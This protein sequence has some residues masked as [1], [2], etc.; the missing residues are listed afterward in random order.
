MS[1]TAPA[2]SYS[3]HAGLYIEFL[4]TD[5]YLPLKER[6]CALLAHTY[7]RRVDTGTLMRVFGAN[8]KQVQNALDALAKV[9]RISRTNGN[10][11]LEV[12]G[13]P[14]VPADSYGLRCLR[15]LLSTTTPGTI[16]TPLGERLAAAL[17]A[18]ENSIPWRL[19][20]QAFQ[21]LE[22]KDAFDEP[23]W[24][25]RQ[26]P[27]RI[28][29]SK[30]LMA[31][32]EKVR[33]SLGSQGVDVQGLGPVEALIVHTVHAAQAV[34]MRGSHIH[35]APKM[36]TRLLTDMESNKGE[37]D[38]DDDKTHSAGFTITRHFYMVEPFAE[39]RS[40]SEMLTAFRADGVDGADL[41]ITDD[42]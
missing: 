36:M 26:L 20:Q 1:N 27:G 30:G 35:H 10:A 33:R 5:G 16:F 8:R 25:A 4:L 37:A 2:K 7:P 15:G 29:K 21:W 6:I 38:G 3:N 13:L 11:R 23:Q 9:G 28:E 18:A 24:W 42:D 40:I 34:E 32:G 31:V 19:D 22:A 14:K 39:R 17:K 41:D 12:G